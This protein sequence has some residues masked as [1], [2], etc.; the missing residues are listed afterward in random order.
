MQRENGIVIG[1]VADLDDPLKLG[2][3]RVRLP[4]LNDQLSDWARVASPMGG[5]DRGLFMRPELEDEVLVVFEQGDPRRASIVGA[6]WSSTDPPPAD[7][8]KPV[9]NNWRFFRSRSGHLLKFDDTRG[10][11]RIEIVGQGGNHRLLIDVSGKKIEIS[12]SSGDIALS[13]PSG[14]LSIDARQVEIRASVAMKLEADGPM[15]IKGSTVAIN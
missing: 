4:H 9:E 11:E 8:G 5:K 6:F 12:C 15:T 10:A 14:T 1:V 2:R 3:A 13:A 7:D